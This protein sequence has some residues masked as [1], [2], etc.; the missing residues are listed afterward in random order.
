M[1]SNQDVAGKLGTVIVRLQSRRVSWWTLGIILSLFMAACGSTL[2]TVEQSSASSNP[3]ESQESESDAD[4]LPGTEEFGLSQEELVTSIE[5]IEG[6]IAS[7]MNEAGFEYIANDYN[8]VR[9][10]MTA[11]KTLPGLSEDEFIEQYGYGIATLYTGLPPQ[12]AD[13]S[14]PAQIGLGEQ[15]VQ[16]FRNLSPEDQ[17]AY[18]RTLFGESEEA[19]LAVAL[20]TEDLSRTG[21]CTR[22]AIEQVFTTEQLNMSYTSPKDIL[23]E[24]DP[25][26]VAALAEYAKCIQEAGFDYNHENEIEP[27]LRNRLDAI[28]KG[29]PLESLSPEDREALT[30]LQGEERAIAVASLECEEEILEPVED[31]V[32]QELFSGG[33][34]Q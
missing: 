16:I 30:A 22:S 32:E 3:A 2:T 4:T 34:Q 13:V 25:R 10:G 23:I 33:T 1:E 11:D 31:Q 7:C 9:Q 27:D 29:L 26:M 28:T 24:Q 17:V 12:L 5:M 18:N 19:T 20:E 6:L 8:T 15:N 14:T 21:G